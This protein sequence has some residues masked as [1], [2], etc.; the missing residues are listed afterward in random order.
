[1]N[2]KSCNRVANALLLA[3][4]L[5]WGLIGLI[6]FNFVAAAFGPLARLVYIAVGWAAL[7]RIF[8]NGNRN[9]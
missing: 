5:N 9:S 4:A 2:G 8:A 3:G 1:M 7:Y 6:G